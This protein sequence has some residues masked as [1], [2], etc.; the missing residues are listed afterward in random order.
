MCRR[1]PHSDTGIHGRPDELPDGRRLD[2]FDGRIQH[3]LRNLVRR[4]PGDRCAALK[5]SRRAAHPRRENGKTRSV[6]ISSPGRPTPSLLMETV[7][8]E[9]R[10]RVSMGPAEPIDLDGL[11]RVTSFVTTLLA[12]RPTQEPAALAKPESAVARISL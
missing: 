2:C 8:N 6:P 11:Q 9:L 5:A 4:P 7:Q 3:G 1:F 10:A 12:D